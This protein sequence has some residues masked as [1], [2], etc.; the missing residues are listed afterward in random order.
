MSYE[1][2]D[3]GT[4]SNGFADHLGKF[5]GKADE[6]FFV[7]YSLSCK[8]FRVFNS[9]K[10]TVEENLHIRFSENTPNVIGSGPDWL[11]NIDALIRTMSYEPIDAGTQSNGFAGTKA[12][13]NAGQAR[14]KK[15]PIKDYILIQLWTADLSFSQDPQSENISNDLPFDPNMHA[16]EDISTFNFSSDH[17]DDDEEAD[18]NNMDT[19]IQASLIPTTRIHKDH[20]LH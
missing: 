1:P 10:I 6:R 2:I 14:K 12:Y 17:Q 3:A 15:E 13:D 4:Q 20:P 7:G 9:R 8:A 18:M 5:N 19:I 16:L 11:F